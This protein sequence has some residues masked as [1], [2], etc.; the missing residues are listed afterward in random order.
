MEPAIRK[1]TF[2]RES[3]VQQDNKTHARKSYSKTTHARKRQKAKVRCKQGAVGAAT[4]CSYYEVSKILYPRHRPDSKLTFLEG[5]KKEKEGKR[6]RKAASL[7]SK[8][9]KRRHLFR[10]SKVFAKQ[11]LHFQDYNLSISTQTETQTARVQDHNSLMHIKQVVIS[12]FRSFRNQSEIEPFRCYTFME[13]KIKSRLLTLHYMFKPKAQCYRR[14]KRVWKI[15]FLRCDPI[16]P[17]DVSVQHLAARREAA[18][19]PRR[20]WCQCHGR[21]C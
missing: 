7:I 12:G 2:P 6:G 9:G 19:A 17:C 21:L 18:F 20:R 10:Q 11:W 14:K 5:R 1:D 13:K 4:V 16:R 3:L 15:K 8:R